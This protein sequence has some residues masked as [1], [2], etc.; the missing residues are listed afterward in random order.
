MDALDERGVDMNRSQATGVGPVLG[1]VNTRLGTLQETDSS[2]SIQVHCIA[3]RAALAAVDAA[4]VTKIDDYKRT[5]NA[6]YSFY[7]HSATQTACLCS[8]VSSLSEE[9]TKSLKQPSAACGRNA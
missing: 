9:D 4:K 2:Y 3:H 5:V 6:V 8:L 1:Q 7:K